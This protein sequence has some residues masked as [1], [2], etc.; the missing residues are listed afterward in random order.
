MSNSIFSDRMTDVP[1]SFI[2]EILKVAVKKDII[3]FA[4]GLPNRNL[5]PLADL[6]KASTKIFTEKDL[7][8]FQ[9]SNSEGYEPLRK[10]IASRYKEKKGLLVD[11]DN[12]LITTGS[13]QALDLIAKALIN[14]GDEI[15]IEEPGYLGAIQA[16]SVYQASFKP[17]PLDNNGIIIE[18]LKNNISS[19]QAKIFYC[20]PNFNNPSGI[21]YSNKRREAVAEAIKDKKLFLIEDDPYGEI[22]F[23]GKQQK[24]FYSIIPEKTIMLGSFSKTV[25]PSFRIGW[26]VAPPNI[27]DKL[28]IGKQA[29]DLHT[30]FFTQKVLYNYLTDSDVDLHIKNISELYGKQRNAMVKAIK[31]YFPA[32]VKTTNPE[33]GMFLWITLP[34]GISSM[35]L[36]DIAI[37][38][39]VAFVPGNP[40]YTSSPKI[41]NTLRLNFSCVD[42]DAIEEG[43]KR[44]GEAIKEMITKKIELLRRD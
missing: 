2:R 9:Y 34:D 33:G 22:R 18:K 16:F 21:T 20:V 11:P 35:D 23:A 31:K 17:V 38:K 24:S 1:R 15:I 26:I 43:I 3:S 37:K 14:P 29:A 10:Y 42:V 7:D 30:N 13:Q 19:N 36:F 44:L 27:L 39:N 25:V 4:G 12:I 6:E 8:A 41:V 40:F 28:I 5:F 32:D